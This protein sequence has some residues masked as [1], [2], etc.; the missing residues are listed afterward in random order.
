MRVAEQ[1]RGRVAEGG[2]AKCLVAVGALANREVSAPALI[3]FATDNRERDHDP[4]TDLEGRFCTRPD[5]DHL[6]HGLMAQDVTGFHAG[7][8]MIIEVEVRSTDRAARNL[9]DRIARHLRRIGID[10]LFLTVT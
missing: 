2:V 7:H 5:V 9:D 6:A 8:E 10:L 4:V 3:T 1:S